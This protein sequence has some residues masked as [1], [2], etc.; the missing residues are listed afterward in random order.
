[1]MA[2]AWHINEPKVSHKD[3]FEVTKF[4]THLSNVYGKKLTVN[5]LKVH[6]YLGMYLDYPDPGVAKV[7]MLNYLQKVLDKFMDELRGTSTTTE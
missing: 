1:M 6:D 7:S 2:V 5:R 3:P 4:S